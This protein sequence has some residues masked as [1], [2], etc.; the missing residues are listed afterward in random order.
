MVDVDELG[1]C[2]EN[3]V[4]HDH[5]DARRSSTSAQVVRELLAKGYCVYVFA[6]Q[7]SAV[8]SELVPQF[9][10]RK[11]IPMDSKDLSEVLLAKQQH[12]KVAVVLH[13]IISPG[14]KVMNRLLRDDDIMVVSISR[15]PAVR[16]DHRYS[17]IWTEGKGWWRRSPAKGFEIITTSEKPSFGG[18]FSWAWR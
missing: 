18:W 3:I 11:H 8:Y 6:G 4:I 12:A 10:L 7:N 1:A 13:G 14:G 15:V 16:G 17:T 9:F 5:N 2:A